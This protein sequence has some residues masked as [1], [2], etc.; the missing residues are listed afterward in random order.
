M[1]KG[2]LPDIWKLQVA[3]W[4]RPGRGAR[5]AGPRKLGGPLKGPRLVLPVAGLRW[6]S[7]LVAADVSLE[8]AAGHESTVMSRKRCWRE[9]WARSSPVRLQGGAEGTGA[10]GP[11]SFSAAWLSGPRSRCSTCADATAP[12]RDLL[13]EYPATVRCSASGRGIPLPE[14]NTQRSGLPPRC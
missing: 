13:P 1:N 12:G 5:L 14:T 4:E 6:A 3:H 7:S 10:L 11:V 9:T 8:Y 2:Q